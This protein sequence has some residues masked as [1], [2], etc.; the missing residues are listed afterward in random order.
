[1]TDPSAPEPGDDMARQIV[2]RL[3]QGDVEEAY[4]LAQ[5]ARRRMVAPTEDLL[6]AQWDAASRYIRNNG[7]DQPAV[8]LAE[9]ARREAEQMGI[10]TDWGS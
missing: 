4:D 9:S 6:R 1:M 10:P 3:N 7:A 8:D 2:A 5:A